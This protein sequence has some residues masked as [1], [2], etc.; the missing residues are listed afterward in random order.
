[1][2][3]PDAIGAV[4]ALSGSFYWAPRGEARYEWLPARVA[5]EPR[6]PIRW[7]VA[8]GSLETVVT[9]GNHGHYLVGTNRHLN[10][11]L[12]A[13]GYTHFYEEFAGV[14][15]EANWEDALATG[16]RRLLPKL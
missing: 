4:L 1:M 13:K 5:R 11:V 16:L 6:K 15:H 7:F 2:N 14:H 8:S 9:P 12:I 10:D 3:R